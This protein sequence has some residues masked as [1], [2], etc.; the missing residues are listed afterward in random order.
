MKLP[1]LLRVQD[2]RV[3]LPYL[4][5]VHHPYEG[6]QVIQIKHVSSLDPSSNDWMP[7]ADNFFQPAFDKR[8]PFNLPGRFM[9]QRQIPVR[10]D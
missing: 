10:L 3:R 2:Y 7:I 8:N 4:P 1:I 5:S 6:K 9:E